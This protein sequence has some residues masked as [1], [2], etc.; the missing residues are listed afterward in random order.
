MYNMGMSVTTKQKKVS[1][2][3]E[4]KDALEVT[5]T[6]GAREQLVELQKFLKAPTELD[7]IK[8]GISILQKFKDD[9]KK[10]KKDESSK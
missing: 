6:N 2:N 8:L 3:G 10:E 4:S 5:F 9:G 7:V 1:E